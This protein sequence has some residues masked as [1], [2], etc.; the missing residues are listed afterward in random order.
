LPE[1]GLEMVIKPS[2]TVRFRELVPREIEYELLFYRSAGVDVVTEF[3]LN[4]PDGDKIIKLAKMQEEVREL[5]GGISSR[6]M[7][8]GTADVI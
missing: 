5:V 7:L 6:A 8:V 1:A 4:H 3:N 2:G